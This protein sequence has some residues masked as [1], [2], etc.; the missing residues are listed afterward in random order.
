MDGNS[1]KVRYLAKNIGL[2]TLSNFATKILSFFLVPLYTSILTTTEYGINDLFV[3]TIGILL[4]VVT[5]NIQESVLRFALDDKYDKNSILR[6]GF[7]YLSFGTIIVVALLV[8]N[9][10]TGTFDI[11]KTYGIFFFLMYFSQALSGLLAAYI[12]GIDRVADL[13]ISSVINSLSIIIC[14][15]LFLVVFKWGIVGYFIANII[16]PFIQCI[17]L[18]L[19]AGI[20]GKSLSSA[21][22]TRI[23][24]EMIEYSKP[25]ILNSIAWWINNAADKYVIVFFLGLT[26]NGIYS[27]AGKI[28]AIL[29]VFQVIFAQ[30][31]TLSAVK[32]FDPEDK[33]GFFS[34]TYA[35]YNCFMVLGCSAII[36]VDKLLARM[37]YAKDFFAAWQYVPWLT[38]AIV[39]GSLA[40]YL[41]G[42]FS[43]VKDS[44]V[45]ARTTL[46][47]AACNIVLNFA[48]TP[49][50][51][52]MGAA[53]ATTVSFFSVWCFRL[54]ISKKYIRFAIR[55]KRDLIT[56]F[57][58]VLQT[59]ILLLLDGP[60]LYGL[61]IGLFIFI[62]LLYMSDIKGVTS[63]ISGILFSRLK[64]D[65]GRFNNTH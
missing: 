28:P 3:T 10:V 61:E 49:F 17:Y 36:V 20:I 58:V 8:L 59:V 18:V 65:D 5:L 41:G 48:L 53:I 16:G 62:A 64:R 9:G 12:R 6:I 15:I 50:I 51:G 38:I 26:E 63:K 34:K 14:N 30:A 29:N 2:L 60:L 39:F 55:L 32:E 45:F 42:F 57:L 37:M 24:K 31:W 13:S 23:S 47:G 21:K 4:P 35:T 46:I 19:R 7:K 43:A 54:V 27:V 25:L 44:K 22:D 40:G 52:A 56:Y 1:G 33:N 11:F